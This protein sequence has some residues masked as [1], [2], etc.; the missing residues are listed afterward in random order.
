M[1]VRERERR[2]HREKKNPFP[3]LSF[4]KITTWGNLNPCS[5]F[6]WDEPRTKQPLALIPDT[7]GLKFLLFYTWGF[8]PH[9]A[10]WPGQALVQALPWGLKPCLAFFSLLLQEAQKGGKGKK[11]YPRHISRIRGVREP[12]LFSFSFYLPFALHEGS[13]RLDRWCL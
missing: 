6:P 5:V 10:V 1:C 2:F 13:S 4:L 11:S 9:V 3:P 8:N 12:F 7:C